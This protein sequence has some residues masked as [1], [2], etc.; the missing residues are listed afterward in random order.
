[1]NSDSTPM[2]VLVLGAGAVGGFYGARLIEA[3]ADVT[4]LVRPKRATVLAERG[5][6]IRSEAASFDRRVAAT[7]AVTASDRY[8][9]VLLTCK[10]Y[11]LDSAMAS[12]APAIDGGAMVVP[13]LNGLAAY[14]RL[15]ARFGRARVLGGAS[16]IATM[17]DRDGTI[18]QFGAAE[19]FLVGARVDDQRELA[20][21]LHALMQRTPGV[22]VLSTDIEQ[23]LWNKW[24]TVATGAAVT[25]LMRGTVAEIL[26]SE[27]G[28][29]VMRQAIAE[30]QSTAER[31]GHPVPDAVKQQIAALLLDRQLAWSASMMR[32][33][34]QG[35]VRLEADDIVGDLLRRAEGF[36]IDAPIF[37]AAYAHLKVYESQKQAAAS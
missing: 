3:G 10:T 11:D 34:A 31:A 30:S 26:K 20:S 35:A 28:E 36:G 37:R 9:V 25:C 14:D 21:R 5:L 13:L 12:I 4:F 8:D 1:M 7:E 33:I 6:V 22:R 32:D 16:Y 24:V 23:D 17:L 18:V 29:Q 2:K 15:D 19:R 27:A